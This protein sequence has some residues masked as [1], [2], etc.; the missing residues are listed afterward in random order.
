MISYNDLF[1]S[2]LDPFGDYSNTSAH[3]VK[4]LM[5]RAID[6]DNRLTQ[7]EREA[8]EEA[9]RVCILG[10]RYWLRAHP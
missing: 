5:Q 10:E 6:R 3:N 7:D 2:R 4:Y 1:S 8:A 9:E